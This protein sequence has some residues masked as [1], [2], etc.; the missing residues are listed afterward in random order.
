MKQA[1]IGLGSN[2]E[3]RIER[4][5]NALSE[6]KAISTVLKVSSLYETEP[7]GVA[8]QAPFIN[9]VAEIETV[10]TADERSSVESLHEKLR[11]AEGRLG[12]QQRERWHEREIDFDILF[13][14][15]AILETPTLTLPHP[16]VQYR[17]FVLEPLAEILPD[18]IHPVLNRTAS[19]LLEELRKSDRYTAV[20][21]L[22]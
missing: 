9:L 7:Y 1:I 15:D 16:G 3:P 21:R 5:Q 8:D 17:S 12:R 18:F 19:E 11:A 14:E 13:F 2:I 4:I 10:D 6:L 22:S 20:R